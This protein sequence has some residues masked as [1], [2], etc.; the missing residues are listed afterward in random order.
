VGNPAASDSRT[1]WWALTP[2]CFKWQ[3]DRQRLTRQQRA[4]TLKRR[5]TTWYERAS[6]N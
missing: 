6:R 1:D 2:P 3:H 4:T 5:G